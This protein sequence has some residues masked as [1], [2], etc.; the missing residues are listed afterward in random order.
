MPRAL[1]TDCHA[2]AEFFVKKATEVT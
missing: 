2:Q 1:A